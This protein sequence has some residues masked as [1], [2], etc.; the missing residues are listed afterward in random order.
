MF[1]SAPSAYFYIFTGAAL[2]FAVYKGVEASTRMC[3]FTLV[4]F[5]VLL[6][7]ILVTQFPAIRLNRLYPAFAD[8]ADKLIAE[9]MKEFSHNNEYII[10]ALLCGDI[11]K[12]SALSVPMYLGAA[13]LIIL[14]MTF[15]Y[16]TVFGRLVSRLDFPFYTLSSVSDMALLHRINGIDAMVWVMAG[17]LRLA[18]FAFAFGN[19]V[20]LCFAG[21]RI[22]GIA[23]AV[24][25]V[26][27]LV[28]SGLFTAYPD[29]Y[30]PVERILSTGL[31]L[32]VT[33][34]IL[35]AAAFICTH[36][37]KAAKQ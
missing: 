30:K 33:A 32:L 9:V 13:G 17:L 7:L 16:N 11:R 5:A 3:T 8:D 10:F 26:L 36:G 2:L 21:E 22:A 14:F 19:I 23:S 18:L 4:G 1:D 24:F 6:I 35:P 27:T 28:L 12:R 29:M 37:R 31:P 25:A 34:V 15:M 20:R